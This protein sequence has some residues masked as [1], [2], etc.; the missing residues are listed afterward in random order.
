MRNHVVITGTGRAGTTFLVQLLTRCGLDTGYKPGEMRLFETANAGLERDIRHDSAPYIV[1]APQFA[2]YH[3][4]ILRNPG[5]F[6]DHAIIPVRNLDDAAKSRI[7]VSIV[8]KKELGRSGPGGLWGTWKSGN[9]REVLA[10]KF[11]TLIAALV[12]ADVPMTFLAFPRFVGDLE[13]SRTKLLPVFPRLAAETFDHAFRETARPELVH[14]YKGR[15][16]GGVSFIPNRFQI[17]HLIKKKL[18]MR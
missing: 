7:A 18:G 10:E 3:H 13:Y 12:E 17:K 11:T 5:I 6:L 16:L 15:D 2:D 1:K 8:N 14:D 9:Q 4:Q